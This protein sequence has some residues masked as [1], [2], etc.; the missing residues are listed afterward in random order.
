VQWKGYTAEE[1]TWEPRENLGN[2]MDLVE[3]FEEDMEKS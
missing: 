1:D 2:A 3:R